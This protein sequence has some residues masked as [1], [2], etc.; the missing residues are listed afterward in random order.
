MNKNC[1]NQ[2][3]C[4]SFLKSKNIN[5]NNIEI[6]SLRC[7]LI[8]IHSDNID[9]ISLKKTYFSANKNF[10][11][12]K[13]IPTINEIKEMI[14][15]AI[16]NRKSWLALEFY[17]I[18]K[19][20]QNIIWMIWINCFNEK[21]PNISI[22]IDELFQWNW[23]WIEVYGSL[24][25]WIKENTNF[26]IIKHGTKHWNFASI[27]LATHFNWKLQSTLTKWWSLKFYIYL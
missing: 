16:S 7:S 14:S 27:K 3:E 5:I 6:D 25:I 19:E 13:D 22:W 17:I 20:S 10:F 18:Q 21:I 23:Y 2:L 8:P 1:N 15:V 12:N 9:F 4:F 24:L 11:I 26:S